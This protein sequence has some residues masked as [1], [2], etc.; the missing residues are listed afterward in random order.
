MYD[1]TTSSRSELGFWAVFGARGKN[2]SSHGYT[3]KTIGTD[4]PQKIPLEFDL[5]G[6]VA[7]FDSYG[8]GLK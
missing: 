3:F 8:F 2:R 4:A 5:E 6:N 7:E 1:T